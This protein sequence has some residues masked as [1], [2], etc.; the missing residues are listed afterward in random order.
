MYLNVFLETDQGFVSERCGAEE[1]D[2]TTTCPAPPIE[3]LT[4]KASLHNAS[5]FDGLKPDSPIGK[6][7]QHEILPKV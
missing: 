2:S 4:V 7:L 6:Q 3:E 5:G 1:Y